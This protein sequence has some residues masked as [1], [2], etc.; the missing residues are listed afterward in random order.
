MG[1]SGLHGMC[2]TVS[3][4]LNGILLSLS[5]SDKYSGPVHERESSQNV[6]ISS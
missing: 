3:G 6:R 5:L 1:A 2:N 4:S